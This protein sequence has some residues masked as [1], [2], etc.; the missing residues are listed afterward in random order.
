MRRSSFYADDLA[1]VHHT[2]FADL[3][4]GAADFLTAELARRGMERAHVVDLGCGSGLLARALMRAGHHVTGVDLS[5]AM[6]RL[7]RKNAP[8]ASF[9]RGSLYD[10]D[11]PQCDVVLA[12]GEPL[13]Y[14]ER[15]G[16]AP[17]VARLFRRVARALPVGG[18]FVFDVIVDGPGPRLDKE[19]YAA[20]DDWA[21]LVRTRED[22]TRARLTREITSFV[23]RGRVFRRTFEVH[24]VRTF[25][26]ADLV[27]QLGEAGFRV[28]V[29]TR[30]GDHPLA[31]RR[32]AFVCTRRP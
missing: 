5:S 10:V 17:S 20:G 29:V 23:R 28:R 24:E 16:R 15:G 31:V 2:G 12:V 1:Y 22:A 18:L 7:A 8:K 11:L 26:R 21:V 14:L 13:N 9:I 4:R 27:R 30:Y 25:S 3:A 6:L 32:R 19:G